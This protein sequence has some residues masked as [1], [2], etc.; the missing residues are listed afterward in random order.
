MYG[1]T[2]YPL[3]PIGNFVGVILALLP[4]FSQVRKLSLAVWGYALWIAVFNFTTFVNTIVWHN[5]VNIVATIWCDIGEDIFKSCAR[6]FFA[7]RLLCTVTKLQLGTSIG[8]RTCALIICVRLYKITRLRSSGE[9][10]S[11]GQ[12][13]FRKRRCKQRRSISF[14]ETQSVY[15]Q[16]FSHNRTTLPHYGSL[17]VLCNS[18]IF[19]NA[20]I[21][22]D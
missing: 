19:P 5:N 7:D 17:Y 15:M 8:T 1:L 9:N 11:K 21:F 3:T 22:G 16:S 13:S 18:S 14:T 20:L 6:V 10:V 12:V 2:P 4:L